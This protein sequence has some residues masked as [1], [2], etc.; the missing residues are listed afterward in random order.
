[1]GEKLDAVLSALEGIKSDISALSKE[2][3]HTNQIIENEIRYNINIIAENHATLD[4]K[5]DMALSNTARYSLMEIKLN[6]ALSE[7]E[8]LKS[9]L[10]IA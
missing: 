1:M 2:I 8:K 4:R 9:K 10:G 5:L 7:I 6:T 3:S